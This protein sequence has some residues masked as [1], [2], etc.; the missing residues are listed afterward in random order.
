MLPLLVILLSLP[1]T[2]PSSSSPGELVAYKTAA[3]QAGRDAN[4]HTR[5]ALWCEAHGLNDERAK[6][7]AIALAVDP[8]HAVARGLLGLVADRGHWETPERVSERLKADTELATKLAEY[9]ARRAQLEQSVAA[10]RSKQRKLLES[11]RSGDALALELRI[12]RKL[13]LAHVKL[14]MW[15]EENGL[16]A[17]ATAHFTTAVTLDPHRDATWQHLGYVRHNG[18]WMTREQIA[19]DKRE[20][21]AQRSADKH[22]EP[23]LQEWKSLLDKKP[24]A[25]EAEESFAEVV[26]PRAVPS[27][28]RVFGTARPSDQDRCVQLLAKIEGPAASRALARLAV[29]S[30]AK[31]V[32]S[33]AIAALKGREP[34]DYVALLIE[35]IHTPVRYEVR[36]VQ[37]PGSEGTLFV[38]TARFEMI[39]KY[40]APPPFTLA[41]SFHGYVGFDPNGLPVVV[42][43]VEMKDLMRGKSGPVEVALLQYEARTAE[44]LAAAQLK[45]GAA[46]QRLLNDIHEIDSFNS[47]AATLNDRII[48]LLQG[49]LDADDLKHDEDAWHKWWYDKLGY[50]YEPPPKVA[51]AQNATPDLYSPSIST[52]FAAGTQ[53]RTLDGPRSIES[54]QVGDQVLSQDVAT[55]T[56]GFE[57]I[58]VVHHNPPAETLRI[59][60]EGDETI[61]SSVY[62]RF[63]RSGLGWAMG[64]ELEP[65]DTLRTLN[66]LVKVK[67]I[68]P[69]PV[70]PLYNLDVASN[71]TFFVGAR[72][73]LV[74]D[75]TLPAPSVEPFDAVPSLV[76]ASGGP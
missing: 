53:V 47:Q 25:E 1:P 61:V 31:A 65:G 34:R 3:A 4:T 8:N 19:E 35:M 44:L 30:E 13:P 57:P 5:L 49:A 37:G 24:S 70:V 67:S 10:A 38:E 46:Q 27:I 12:R 58:L 2:V 14:G 43:G 7:L 28:V 52:C 64:R 76:T 56:L 36:P 54:L 32:R 50:R 42:K 73:T 66:G 71:R 68:Q 6:Q 51:L 55:G 9:N 22:W 29:F 75:N 39:R 62:H 18:R 26:D 23:L 48:A 69:G 40:T 15:C 60:L 41:S 33:R 16:K 59:A 17:E 72:G 21:E 74:H 45:A 63:W 11:G 20:A